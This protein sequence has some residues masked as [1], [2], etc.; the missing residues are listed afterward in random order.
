VS[1][2]DDDDEALT[3]AGGRDPSHYET[4]V[5]KEPKPLS[6]RRARKAAATAEIAGN[7]ARA[8]PAKES[9]QVEES[10]N[11]SDEE[12]DSD[13]SPVTSGALLVTMGILAGVYLLYTVG[14]I[15]SLRRVI[16][17]PVTDLDQI[18]F[19]AQQYLAI[20]GPVLWFGATLWFTRGHKPVWRLLWLVLGALLLIPWSFVMGS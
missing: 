8:T 13:L 10:A 3:W 7:S 18:F 4:P 6:A 1:T 14:W 17:T 9:T 20:A 11:E 16:Y 15:V 2:D 12:P 19:H 5:A